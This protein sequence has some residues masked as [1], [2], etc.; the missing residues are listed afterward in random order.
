MDLFGQSPRP[1]FNKDMKAELA[2]II[3]KEIFEWCEG[4]TDLEDCISDFE[5][6]YKYHSNDNGYELAKQFEREGYSPDGALVELLEGIWVDKNELI[7][8]AVKKWVI[9][10]DIK[11]S[12]E[13]GTNVIVQYGNKKV[14]GTITGTY[15]ET[16][17]YKV[18][19]PSEGMTIEG[20]RRAIIK[21]ENVELINQINI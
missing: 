14:E 11:P 4:E 6:I 18:M 2:K 16:A 12:I 7:R 5:E 15:L 1:S 3:G 9:E 17:E 13:I 10:D 20:T 8:N 21:Y 19:I